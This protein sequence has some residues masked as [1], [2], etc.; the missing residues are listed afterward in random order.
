MLLGHQRVENLDAVI[1]LWRSHNLLVGGLLL[2]QH[3]RHDTQFGA[4]GCKR[5]MIHLIC[6]KVSSMSN[7]ALLNLMDELCIY[8]RVLVDQGT[9]E[10]CHLQD[11]DRDLMIGVR[12]KWDQLGPEVGIAQSSPKAE[13]RGRLLVLRTRIAESTAWWCQVHVPICHGGV[14]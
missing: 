9:Q 6:L 13:V 8:F 5:C 3:V 4:Q 14:Q 1:L 10:P 12:Q 7:P 2:S 11:L